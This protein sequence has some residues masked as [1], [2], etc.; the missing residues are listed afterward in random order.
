VSTSRSNASLILQGAAQATA[1]LFSNI[2][3]VA[4][5]FYLYLLI[6]AQDIN[7]WPWTF[8]PVGMWALTYRQIL[9]TKEKRNV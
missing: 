1:M 2:L 3:F 4:A 5:V 9:L 7:L 8:I 6:L